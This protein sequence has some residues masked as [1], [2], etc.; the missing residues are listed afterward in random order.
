VPSLAKKA[1]L[2]LFSTALVWLVAWLGAKALAA[3][4]GIGDL[5]MRFE[6][7]LAMWERAPAFGYRNRPGF[8]GT[9]WG[10]VAVRV[11]PQGFR[12]ERGV[13]QARDPGVLRVV[14]LGDSVTWGAGVDEEHTYAG[15][16][17][18]LFSAAGTAAEVV[19][20]GVV[21]Y[22]A[23]QEELLLERRVLELAPDV[24]LV[25]LCSN[26]VL[27]SEDPFGD[28]RAVYLRYL[29]RLLA[30]PAFTWSDSDRGQF[31]AIR[32]VFERGER[33]D[34]LMA[35]APAETKLFAVRLFLELPAR[36]MAELCAAR[37]ARLVYLLVPPREQDPT[38]RLFAGRVARAVRAAGGE[39]L[40]LAPAL[41]QDA[42]VEKIEAAQDFPDWVK[43]ALRVPPLR[44]IN[45][46][47]LVR[48]F[49]RL[50]HTTKYIDAQH[51]SRS[52]HRIIAEAV[53]RHL[54]GT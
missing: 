16:L 41:R 27:P 50:H 32:R 47:L 29:D 48:R 40:D 54:A 52:G 22:S 21:G 26:D 18:G 23:L 8:V 15:V 1:L 33:V 44:E 7:Q 43:R 37:G 31:A 30:D 19:N 34:P 36:R 11:G 10:R 46:I 25:Q 53:W 14:A 35:A 49:E 51:P 38:Y 39:V 6:H 9:S 12:G 3:S 20:A 42:G 4:L 2:A 45:G 28:C 24:V 13:A 5:D 17:S